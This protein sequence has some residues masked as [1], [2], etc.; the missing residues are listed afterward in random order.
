MICYLLLNLLGW[1]YPIKI[2][3]LAYE[4]V[5][6]LINNWSSIAIKGVL[7]NRFDLSFMCYIIR[8]IF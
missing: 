6:L 4:C 7:Y 3:R 5:Y 8:N 2:P 1:T